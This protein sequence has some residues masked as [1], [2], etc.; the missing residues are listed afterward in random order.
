LFKKGHQ[1]SPEREQTIPTTLFG[2][3]DCFKVATGMDPFAVLPL[4]LAVGVLRFAASNPSLRPDHLCAALLVNRRWNT[5]AMQPELWADL[6]IT[7]PTVPGPGKWGRAELLLLRAR[8]GLQSL[9]MSDDPL[10]SPLWDGAIQEATSRRALKSLTLWLTSGR[11][12][13]SPARAAAIVDAVGSASL[14]SLH[15]HCDS[16][17]PILT[18]IVRGILQR[19]LHLRDLNFTLGSNC[20]DN[21]G[22]ASLSSWNDNGVRPLHKLQTLDV[23]S[24]ESPS[25]WVW[26]HLSRLGVKLTSVRLVSHVYSLQQLQRCDPSGSVLQQVLDVISGPQLQHYSC[27]D[28]GSLPIHP[29]IL[30]AV[31]EYPRRSLALCALHEPLDHLGP[32]SMLQLEDLRLFRCGKHALRCIF[33]QGFPQLRRLHLTVFD[34]DDASLAMG[35]RSASETLESVCLSDWQQNDLS[36]APFVD[37]TIS[38]IGTLKSLRNLSISGCPGVT[39]AMLEPIL[40]GKHPD[41]PPLC[42]RV[43][44]AHIHLGKRSESREFISR[45]RKSIRRRFPNIA[46]TNVADGWRVCPT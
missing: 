34:V 30:A 38:A 37:Q 39:H 36:V 44:A 31:F 9:T 20:V 40:I 18:E 24:S 1:L 5:V 21:A 32:N 28:F 11:N 43:C 41:Q 23:R 27:C 15:I 26:E 19:S 12:R 14:C 8:G 46:D 3:N 7:W 13:A 22:M 6:E 17:A 4:E 29:S 2:I 25:P 35:L 33:R 10:S 16:P 45:L 42:P